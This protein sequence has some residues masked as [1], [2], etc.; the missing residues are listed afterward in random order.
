[1]QGFS[2]DAGAAFPIRR[3]REGVCRRL[4]LKILGLEL[5]PYDLHI[6]DTEDRQLHSTYIIRIN[7]VTIYMSMIHDQ[8]V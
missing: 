1:M 2:S 7:V 6:W 3:L 8:K 4:R 5:L